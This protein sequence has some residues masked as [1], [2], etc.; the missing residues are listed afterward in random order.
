MRVRVFLLVLSILAPAAA[1]AASVDSRSTPV[2]SSAANCPPTASS[3]YAEKMREQGGKRLTPK[4]LTEL[5][6]ATTYMAV[7]RHI[8]VCE[9]P[10]TMVDYRNPRRR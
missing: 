5:P 6:P 9:A 8:G 4:K 7:Y 10:L 2:G 3:Y 1:D